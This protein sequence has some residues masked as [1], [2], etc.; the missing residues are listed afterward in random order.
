MHRTVLRHSKV[1]A[2]VA[3]SLGQ[4]ACVSEAPRSAAAEV[5]GEDVRRLPPDRTNVPDVSLLKADRGR[6]IGP[7]SAKLSLLVVSDY[8]CTGCRA[9]FEQT[10]PTIRAAY[11]DSGRLRLVWVHYPLR[12][13]PAAVRAAN[14][15]LCASVQ[16]YFW[17]ASAA[18]FASQAAWGRDS[19][20][21]ARIDSIASVQGVEPS[22]LQNCTQTN[23]M[24]RQ[25]HQ[26]IAWADTVHAGAP[27]IVV[28]G[29]HHVPGSAPIATLRAAIDSALAGR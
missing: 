12:E 5:S 13:H 25:V 18:L 17:E 15:A 24:L 2:F 27:P 29:N 26:D 20:S 16:G 6:S 14:A 3:L 8:Q 10:L 21:S 19:M 9:W 28:V 7:D 22:L 23:R 4:V 1:L 11:P